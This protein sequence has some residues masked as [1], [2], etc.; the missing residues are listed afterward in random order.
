MM[1]MDVTCQNV[2]TDVSVGNGVETLTSRIVGWFLVYAHIK[3]VEKVMRHI[4]IDDLIQ[5]LFSSSIW[6]LVSMMA[7]ASGQILVSFLY[8]SSL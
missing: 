7:P 8:M 2:V 3:A 4:F 5:K 1:L 6:V